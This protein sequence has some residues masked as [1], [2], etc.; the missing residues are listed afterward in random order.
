MCATSIHAAQRL[1][2]RARSKPKPLTP[3]TAGSDRGGGSTSMMD[4]P[5]SDRSCSRRTRAS[6]PSATN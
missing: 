6:E 2:F 4:T 1:I 5:M 3:D